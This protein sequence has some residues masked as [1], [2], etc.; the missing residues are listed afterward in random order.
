MITEAYECWSKWKVDK[1]IRTLADD[2]C[3]YH[4]V[5]LARKEPQMIL[6]EFQ[7][8]KCLQ[9]DVF[10]GCIVGRISPLNCPINFLN[11]MCNLW[12][13]IFWASDQC[14]ITWWAKWCVRKIFWRQK[15]FHL[16]DQD[17][18]SLFYFWCKQEILDYLWDLIYLIGSLQVTVTSGFSFS[19][20]SFWVLHTVIST[21]P[22]AD[23]IIC[24]SLL[25]FYFL[26]IYHYDGCSNTVASNG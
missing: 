25:P 26:K 9:L 13:I 19:F 6:L 18:S 7:L 4:L 15:Q 24:A 11:F 1:F 17:E 2:P 20:S 5:C 16:E 22:G 21:S 23:F 14:G 8:L 10:D 3:V 12:L